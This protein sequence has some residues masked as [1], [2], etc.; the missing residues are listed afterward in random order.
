LEKSIVVLL[1]EFLL[2]RQVVDNLYVIK[3]LEEKI[4]L[5]V[6][7]SLLFIRDAFCFGDTI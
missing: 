5:V 4:P 1:I 2:L 7:S 3:E 6:L